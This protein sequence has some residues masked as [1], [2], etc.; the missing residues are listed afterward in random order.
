MPIRILILILTLFAA[1][2][3]GESTPA[4]PEQATQE[5]QVAA[6]ETAG[7]GLD[8]KRKDAD[9]PNCKDARVDIYIVSKRQGAEID[10]IEDY[11]LLAVEV[12]SDFAR[13]ECTGL[14][15]YK[16]GSTEPITYW[17]RRDAGMEKG[18]YLA[19]YY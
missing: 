6:T 3:C 4:S 13:I 16:N 17:I 2:A 19:G 15:K 10:D 5:A 1:I 14:A 8:Q 9:L 18:T 11:A 7:Q 12:Q